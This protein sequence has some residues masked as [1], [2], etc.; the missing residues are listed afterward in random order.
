MGTDGLQ[1]PQK[2]IPVS[3]ERLLFIYQVSQSKKSAA[4]KNF[5]QY[6]TESR[7]SSDEKGSC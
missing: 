7:D 2:L 6:I 3:F 4:L 5:V 1:F